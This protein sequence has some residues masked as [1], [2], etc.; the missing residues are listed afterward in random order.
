MRSKQTTRANFLLF[1]NRAVNTRTIKIAGGSWLQMT[2][3]VEF[4]SI[5]KALPP[6]IVAIIYW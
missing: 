1:L 4:E 3:T 5:L 2:P 6:N